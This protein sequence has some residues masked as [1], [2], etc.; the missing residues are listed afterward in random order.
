MLQ[1]APLVGERSHYEPGTFLLGRPVLERACHDRCR[2]RQAFFAGLLGWQYETDE[3]GY[4]SIRNGGRLNGG[5]RE[6][7]EQERGIPP[8][9]LPYFT[10]ENV[11]DAARRAERLGGRLL[12]RATEIHIGRF[13]VIAD[14]LGA[15]FAVLEGETDP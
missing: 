13:A 9:W 3:S 5:V 14:L 7:T 2:A 6:Q 11:D 4:A 8:N 1:Y 12:S 15:A 10:V